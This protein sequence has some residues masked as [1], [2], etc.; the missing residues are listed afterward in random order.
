[1]EDHLQQSQI[2][3]YLPTTD[4]RPADSPA[5]EESSSSSSDSARD[6]V[7]LQLSRNLLDQQVAQR[8]FMRSVQDRMMDMSESISDVKRAQKKNDSSKNR[9]VMKRAR[10]EEEEESDEP[11]IETR[12]ARPPNA[13]PRSDAQKKLAHALMCCI[14]RREGDM[15]AA[16]MRGALFD[17]LNSYGSHSRKTGARTKL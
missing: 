14:A 13:G 1:M 11:R 17:C 3:T 8:E 15:T 5:V 12:I 16:E 6:D 9:I 7:L 4:V 2:T 10:V